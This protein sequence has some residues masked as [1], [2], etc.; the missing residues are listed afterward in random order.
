MQQERAEK[1][2][3]WVRTLQERMASGER[4]YESSVLSEDEIEPFFDEADG[5]ESDATNESN[6]EVEVSGE[7][8]DAAG[9]EDA[10]DT[11]MPHANGAPDACAA[12]VALEARRRGRRAARD[13]TESRTSRAGRC[14]ACAHQYYD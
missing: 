7:D 2:D 11:P 12:R 13:F 6:L 1:V 14:S 4:D 8:A 5:A 9:L 3:G 10:A